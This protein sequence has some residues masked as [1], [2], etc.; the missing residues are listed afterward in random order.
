MRTAEE[1]A[2]IG[3]DQLYEDGSELVADWRLWD[4]H[5]LHRGDGGARAICGYSAEVIS[6]SAAREALQVGSASFCTTC[7]A[8]ADHRAG[9]PYE[10][11]L[12]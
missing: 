5:E 1:W 12:A 8:A 11:D 2:A 7:V 10:E 9:Y 6:L 4:G 3:L